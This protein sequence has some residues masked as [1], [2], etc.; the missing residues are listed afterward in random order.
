MHAH[1][2]SQSREQICR[3]LFCQLQ[4]WVLE[5][6]VSDWTLWNNSSIK[7]VKHS[8]FISTQLHLLQKDNTKDIHL[9]IHKGT[10]ARSQNTRKSVKPNHWLSFTSG[11]GGDGGYF[12]CYF[13]SEVRPSAAAFVPS[14]TGSYSKPGALFFQVFSCLNPNLSDKRKSPSFVSSERLQRSWLPPSAGTTTTLRDHCSDTGI[15]RGELIFKKH[16][17]LCL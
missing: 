4:M 5:A 6:D 7:E 9:S 11:G 2:C 17:A 15:R 1:T 12:W 3:A 13:W 16:T 8:A 10:D 14:Q